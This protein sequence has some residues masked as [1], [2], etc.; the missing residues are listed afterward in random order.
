MYFNTD[1]VHF[2]FWNYAWLALQARKTKQRQCSH[3]VYKQ[4]W[5]AYSTRKALIMQ[6]E[7][8]AWCKFTVI[9]F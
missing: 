9:S 7:K 5:W 3:W 1:Y 2:E 6:K 4:A 8:I